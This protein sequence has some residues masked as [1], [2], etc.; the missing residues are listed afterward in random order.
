[1]KTLDLTKR[2]WLRK[3]L[4]F[5]DNRWI[6]PEEVTIGTLS[7]L[8]VKS[9][10]IWIILFAAVG[11]FVV[12]LLCGLV[13]TPLLVNPELYTVYNWVMEWGEAGVWFWFLV[14]VVLL[15]CGIGEILHRKSTIKEKIKNCMNIKVKI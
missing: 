11:P 12:A 14:S 7:A 5:T 2:T 13:V 1:M 15:S 6:I 9:L 8:V 3:W 10:L 4:E